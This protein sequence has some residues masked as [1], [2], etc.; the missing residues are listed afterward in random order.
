[1]EESTMVD[2]TGI[3]LVCC[4]WD[5]GADVPQHP[6]SR[7]PV[8][9]RWPHA[10]LPLRRFNPLVASFCHHSW[11]LKSQK[12]MR[13]CT[14][15]RE[16]TEFDQRAGMDGSLAVAANRS[17]GQKPWSSGFW[18]ASMPIIGVQQHLVSVHQADLSLAQ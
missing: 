10:L 9:P 2:G 1:M 6:K 8:V 18:N 5:L 13:S 4:I 7:Q 14:C 17:V 11:Q 16:S 15:T 12:A 3:C